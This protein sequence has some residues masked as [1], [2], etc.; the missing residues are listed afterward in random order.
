MA[1]RQ[2]LDDAG[3]GAEVAVD[4]EGRVG[5]EQVGVD[6]APA[7]IVRRAGLDQREQPR[8]QLERALAV[9]QARP[10]VDLPA[11]APARGLVAA[12]LVRTAHRRE[13]RRRRRGD[14]P[15]RVEAVEVREVAVV[16]LDLLEL[17]APFE[18]LPLAADRVR[19][20]LRPRVEQLFAEWRVDPQSLGRI[21]GAREQIAHERQIHGR[22]GRDRAR[23]AAEPELVLGRRRRRGDEVALAVVHEPV[24]AELGGAAQHRIRLVA[25]P[26]EVAA[27]QVVLV[28]VLRQPRPGHRPRGP[29]R[30]AVA[31]VADH[32]G[33]PP[34]VGVVVRR[35]AAR[36]VHRRR[37]P[38]AGDR[39]ITDERE[40]R[41]VQLGEVGRF[42][43]PVVHLG[44]DVDRVVRA[45]R[46]PHVVVPDALQ[47]GGLRAGPARRDQQ[48][49]PVLEE[50]LD[51]TGID[52][53]RA[54]IRRSVGRSS[55]GA[56]GSSSVR[57]SNSA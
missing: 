18:Q 42:R 6:A 2:H 3:G 1:L 14:V 26:G 7:A 21:G 27:V 43:R 56:A 48:V 16:R 44:V 35:P 10:L 9:E 15:A 23:L 33:V 29:H 32:A 31:P 12:Q 5:V 24:E 54:A 11:H 25:Q 52:P 55:A 39:Q 22:A 37:G 4:L 47:V 38:R 57:R 50:Q 20:Q 8:Q 17:L 30:V 45:P 34:D 53:P 19:P 51:E 40:E 13:Q 36:A 49:A 41:L 46:R 28:E